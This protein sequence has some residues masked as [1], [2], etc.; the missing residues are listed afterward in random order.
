MSSPLHPRCII[1]LNKLLLLFWGFPGDSDGK[2]SAC[3]AGDPVS[4]PELG[5]SPGEGT[6]Y[7]LQG[8][9]KHRGTVKRNCSATLGQGPG[10]LS[11][12]IHNIFEL[13]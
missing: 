6:G 13:F 4:I 12:N 8:M 11:R 5:R 9:W 10:S 1:M 3:S 2:E 7:T